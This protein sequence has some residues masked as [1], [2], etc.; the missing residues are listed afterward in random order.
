MIFQISKRRE[1]ESFEDYLKR[2]KAHPSQ[3][4]RR[5]ATAE[6]EAELD[7]TSTKI[8][9]GVILQGGISRGL[10]KKPKK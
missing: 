8:G 3:P 10:G 1:G 5:S 9:K 7:I 4:D 6:E 2:N